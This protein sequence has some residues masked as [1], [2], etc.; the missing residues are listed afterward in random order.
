M[1]VDGCG[2]VWMGVDG[3]GWVWMGVCVGCCWAAE[4]SVAINVPDGCKFCMCVHAHVY[5]YIYVG[6]RV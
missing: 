3:C 2:W 4:Q 6:F 1:G 5:L